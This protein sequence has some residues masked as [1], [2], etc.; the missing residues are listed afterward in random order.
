MRR[1]SSHPRDSYASAQ[2]SLASKASTSSSQSACC[3]SCG[4]STSAPK[5]ARAFVIASEPCQGRVVIDW[6][7][8]TQLS[9]SGPGRRR[10]SGMSSWCCC[11]RPQSDA[12]S[13][14]AFSSPCVLAQALVATDTGERSLGLHG[15]SSE[16][17][18][19]NEGKAAGPPLTCNESSSA[20]AVT[21]ATTAADTTNACGRLSRCSGS[22]SNRPMTASLISAAVSRGRFAG[23]SSQI[24][25]TNARGFPASNGL[26]RAANS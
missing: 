22:R 16:F 18:S 9:G 14:A 20:G 3:S 2:D 17:T 24:L 7:P 1:R 23:G 25:L 15:A 21:R 13:S 8:V 12:T 26:F 19:S 10:R 11:C 5:A 4:S 6:P